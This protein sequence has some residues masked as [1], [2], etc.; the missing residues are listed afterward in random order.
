M[1]RQSGWDGK[2][3]VFELQGEWLEIWIRDFAVSPVPAVAEWL[4]GD[5]SGRVFV[6]TGDRSS[7]TNA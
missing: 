3:P 6:I 2:A 4:K 5:A 1:A 7:L